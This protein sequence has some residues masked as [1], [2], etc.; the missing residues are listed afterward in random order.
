MVFPNIRDN[1]TSN[2][3]ILTPKKQLRWWVNNLLIEKFPGESIKYYSFDE[4]LD[5]T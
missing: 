4:T 5:T 1:V 3:A 2:R